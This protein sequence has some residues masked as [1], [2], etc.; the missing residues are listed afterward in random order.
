MQ[1][2]TT[3]PKITVIAQAQQS[4]FKKSIF[5]IALASL[6]GITVLSGIVNLVSAFTLFTNGV[7][8]ELTRS[9]L[10]D[11]ILDIAVGSL[12]VSSIK[13]FD[14]GKI[15]A[16]WLYGGSIILDSLYS[17][18]RGYELHFIM[19]GLSLLMIWQMLKFRREWEIS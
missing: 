7:M 8:P 19:I 1:H 13:A 9:I 15:L 11:A 16:I 5:V 12:I 4:V 6:G 2:I 18:L 10:T 14:K 17:L 3:Q